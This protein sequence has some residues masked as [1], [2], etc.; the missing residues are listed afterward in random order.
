MSKHVKKELGT[1]CYFQI[2][3]IRRVE[4]R[5]NDN[6]NES[7]TTQLVH[8]LVHMSVGKHIKI[9]NKLRVRLGLLSRMLQSM[10]NS[11]TSLGLKLKNALI[12]LLG[13]SARICIGCPICQ[14][15]LHT[16]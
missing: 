9:V 4:L 1:D 6:N 2:R 7:I 3:L 12:T 14:S 15:A 8:A 5:H 10:M 13:G 16:T 11:A